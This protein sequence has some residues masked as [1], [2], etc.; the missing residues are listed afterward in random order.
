MMSV[1]SFARVA[2]KGVDGPPV[3][4]ACLVR[5]MAMEWTQ[6][7]RI[8]FDNLRS[9]NALHSLVHCCICRDSVHDSMNSTDNTQY[10]LVFSN[11]HGHG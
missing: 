9:C 8:H 7:S 10:L 3:T 4:R 11:N 6:E 2:S 1:A 5:R